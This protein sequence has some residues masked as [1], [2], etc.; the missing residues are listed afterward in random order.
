MFGSSDA[1][2]SAGQPWEGRAF[3]ENPFANDDGTASEFLLA[4]LA[5]FRSAA[6]NDDE[7]VQAQIKVVDAIRASRFLIP[8]LAEAGDIGVN[9]AGLVVDKTQELA[10]VTVEGP[11]GQRVLPVFSSVVAMQAWNKDARPVPVEAR[12]VAL[13]AAADG[14]NWVVI[15]PTSPTEYLLRRP[16]VEAIAQALPWVPNTLDPLLREVL[17]AS[18]HDEP[19]VH[20]VRL[21][22]GDL[23]ARGFDAD[24]IVQ[25]VIS[26]SLD[27]E[28]LTRIVESLSHKWAGEPII[29]ER[30]DSMK[31]VFVPAV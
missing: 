8:L 17:D 26:P 27:D 15:D 1:A 18:I 5:E 11:G 31:L 21:Q 25:L 22:A 2:D 4:A 23:D 14:A 28:A 16:A 13:A 20:A 6:I 30:I 3:D 29:S 9:A 12:R 10:I 7:S 19:L 24:L